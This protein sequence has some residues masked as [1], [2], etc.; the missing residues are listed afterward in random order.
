MFHHSFSF[1]HKHTDTL[2]TNLHSSTMVFHTRIAWRARFH[3]ARSRQPNGTRQIFP[4]DLWFNPMVHLLS[5]KSSWT[6]ILIIFFYLVFM[7]GISLG[8]NINSGLKSKL[9]PVL[10]CREN[11]TQSN[12]SLCMAAYPYNFQ[13]L[14]LKRI[15]PVCNVCVRLLKA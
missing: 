9:R 5:L 14:V 3:L 2:K 1:C 15:T 12:R 6:E 7:G 13:I 10:L 11:Y 4:A 8:A